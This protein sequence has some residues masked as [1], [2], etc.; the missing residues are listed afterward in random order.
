MGTPT[1]EAELQVKITGVSPD[2][3][4]LWRVYAVDD[5]GQG[6]LCR[7][8]NR[9]KTGDTATLVLNSPGAAEGTMLGAHAGHARHRMP[10]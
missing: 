3:E 7:T 8:G 1:T 2:T 10:I 9:V 5:T 4:G 6:W